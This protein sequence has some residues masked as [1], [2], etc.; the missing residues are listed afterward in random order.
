MMG[1]CCQTFPC[2]LEKNPPVRPPV[3]GGC[4]ASCLPRQEMSLDW[5]AR[6][7]ESELE[8]MGSTSV[9]Q[10]RQKPH[11]EVGK[12]A[13]SKGIPLLGRSIGKLLTLAIHVGFS[14]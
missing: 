3:P 13:L 1:I 5:Q 14:D 9:Y 2:Q 12:F 8:A 11:Q 4:R 7:S 6:A 10:H